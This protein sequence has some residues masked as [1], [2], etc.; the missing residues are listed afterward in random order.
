MIATLFGNLV[1]YPSYFSI[2]KYIFPSHIIN[3]EFNI[4]LFAGWEVGKMEMIIIVGELWCKFHHDNAPL[5]ILHILCRVFP[6]NFLSRR[7]VWLLAC[8]KTKIVVKVK[9]WTRLRDHNK[10]TDG[11]PKRGLCRLLKDGKC[12]EIGMWWTIILILKD[13]RVSQQIP[14]SVNSQYVFVCASV[15]IH[16]C[17]YACLNMYFYK[18]KNNHT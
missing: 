1:N 15:Y 17:I 14:D 12:T 16:T 5:P 10:R 8:V 9:G 3:H 2:I 4:K 18:G 7:S 11:D 6:Q 13:R